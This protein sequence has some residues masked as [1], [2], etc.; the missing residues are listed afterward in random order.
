MLMCRCSGHSCVALLIICRVERLLEGNA[1]CR[2]LKKVTCKGTLR[3]VIICPETYTPPYI[4]YT[5]GER[6]NSSQSSVDKTVPNMTDNI[7]R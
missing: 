1:K 4:L 6:G 2:H 5:E 7:S 3:H